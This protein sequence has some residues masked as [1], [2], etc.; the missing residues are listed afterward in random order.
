MAIGV[1]TALDQAGLK[2]PEDIA[3][4]GFDDIYLARYLTPPLTTVRAPTEE[5]GREAIQLLIQQIQG[6]DTDPVVLLPT[7]LVIRQ[8]CGCN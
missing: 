7:E 3:L 6:Q 1:L 4:V 5:V 8:S 2:V